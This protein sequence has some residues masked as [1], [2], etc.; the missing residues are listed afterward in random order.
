VRDTSGGEVRG[1]TQL[2]NDTH[3]YNDAHYYPNLAAL[4]NNRAILSWTRGGDYGDIYYAV[5]NSSG[6]AAKGITNLSGDG[7]GQWDWS[8]DAAY[9]LDGKTVVAWTGGSYPNY[10]IRFAVL[11][12]NYNRISGPTTL[13][14]PAT[15]TGSAYV[16][17]AP[18]GNNAVLTWMDYNYAYRYNL[19]YALV[20]S[21]STQITP[22]QIFRTSQA[23]SP[24]IETSYYG[25]GNTS[26]GVFQPN[27]DGYNFQNTSRPLPS[28]GTF[29]QTFANS[30]L[31]YP[32]GIPKPLAW[33]FYQ[34][35]YRNAFS[36]VCDGMSSTTV[37]YYKGNES[38]PSGTITTYG[39][40]PSAAWPLIELYHGRQLSKG[41]Q[42]YRNNLWRNNPG[43]DGVYNQL[44]A[45]L[46][47][48]MND[49]FVLSFVPGPNNSIPKNQR[50]G[51][52]VIPYWVEEQAGAWAKVYVYDPN[53]PG[54]RN[55]YFYFNFQTSPHSFEYD[56][57]FPIPQGSQG[58]YIVRSGNGWVI[59]PTPLSQFTS[60]DAKVLHDG[61][62]GWLFGSG[63]VMHSNKIGQQ[64]G[65]VQGVFVSTIPNSAPMYQW[66]SPGFSANVFGFS[67]PADEY[68]AVVNTTG[69][70]EYIAS[71]PTTAVDVQVQ[72]IGG[73]QL[74]LVEQSN[75][76]DYIRIGTQAMTA[77][78]SSTLPVGHSLSFQLAGNQP[79]TSRQYGV[80]NATMTG[81]GSLYAE[82]LSNGLYLQTLGM[83]ST[84]DLHIRGP[85]GNTTGWFVHQGITMTAGAVMT[86]EAPALNSTSVVTISVS[87]SPGG[88]VQHVWVLDN[89]VKRV[90]LPIVMR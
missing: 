79:T 31:E 70:Y 74:Q 61:L 28:W 67:L 15:T 82:A 86:I 68:Q 78:Y 80:L 5:L 87:S 25:Q 2:T 63:E 36:G 53:F 60:Y 88:P 7:A 50:F 62:I 21:D 35:T 56:M 13:N 69:N 64:L 75:G 89:Q 45:R 65:Y 66:V 49:P 20:K 48:W 1:I 43:V 76:L 55:R 42:N 54:D 6:N 73:T 27:P 12:A 81:P 34:T 40:S 57:G 72:G 52:S 16:S 58:N 9:L 11:D 51:H 37:S 3:S 23:S 38:R 29:K 32:G 71:S 10:R 17:V 8:S 84:F 24:Y 90:Y 46:P 19:Y 30:D 22:P 14:N 83:A 33:L 44:K 4:S 85:E 41:L 18:S 59:E 47:V 39:L 26:S 77:T